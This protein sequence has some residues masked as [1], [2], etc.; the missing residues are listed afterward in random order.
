MGS[1]RWTALLGG[2]RGA[3]LLVGAA[4]V[5]IYTTASL[6][7]FANFDEGM[8][9][10]I[11]DQA[12]RSLSQFH[13]PIASM[14][15]PGMNLWGDH[16]HPIIILAAPFYWIWDDPRMLFLVQSL[17]I[18]MTSA[19]II[20]TAAK[21]YFP[22]R[23][24]PPVALGV[25]FSASLGVA[26]GAL[27]DFHEVALG[28]PFLALALASLLDRR[29]GRTLGFS[30]I[31]LLV[32]E[33]AGI[34]VFGVGLVALIRGMRLVGTTIMAA[35]VA[36]SLLVV[37][38]IIPAISPIGRWVYG[39]AV[40]GLPEM[41]HSALRAFVTQGGLTLVIVCLLV[42]YL[43]LPVRSW[44]VLAVV[45]NIV[46]R[47]V[48]SNPSYWA[49]SFHYNLLP[50]V[51]IAFAAMEVLGTKISR[52]QLVAKLLLVVAAASVLVGPL[53]RRIATSVNPTRVATATQIMSYVP[54][55]ATVAADA[56]LTPHLTKRHPITQLVRPVSPLDWPA[57]SD[58]L[59]R[60]LVADY[61][62]IDRSMVSNKLP[63]DWASEGIEY[64]RQRGYTNT[65]TAGDYV[66][67][68][69]DA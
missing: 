14:K 58:D 41:A 35:S 67:M 63:Y 50:S 31:V 44:L 22:T 3:A 13:W 64:F 32:K 9:L 52:T 5:V 23:I 66:L 43:G 1:S 33:D 54:D 57:F 36:W 61:L 47:A 4:T 28:M 53:P 45:P 48:S 6:I 34:L 21:L 68:Q 2:A 20:R 59:Q 60:E 46:S 19:I 51:I 11:F 30:A 65:Q 29:P 24:L 62:I 69:R 7:L 55:G 10:A 37:K 39:S 18:A 40:G 27:F 16:F 12:V 38:V 17:A 15:S 56:Y 42:A 25:A 26:S 8:D 49:M